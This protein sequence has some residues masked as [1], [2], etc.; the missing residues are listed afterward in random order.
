[1]NLWSQ[2]KGQRACARAFLAAIRGQAE[3]PIP[4]HEILEVARASIGIAH[5]PS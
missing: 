2:D 1:M 5:D 3:A 4:L